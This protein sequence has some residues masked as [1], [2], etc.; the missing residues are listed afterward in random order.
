MRKIAIILLF[1]SSICSA[2]FVT[3]YHGQLI[4][5]NGKPIY[6]PSVVYFYS[7]QGAS[8]VQSSITLRM[9]TGHSCIINWGDG[10]TTNVTATTN[11]AYTSSYTLQNRSILIQITGDLGYIQHFETSSNNINLSTFSSIKLL[12]GLLELKL[13]NCSASLLNLANLNTGLTQL[14]TG[15]VQN[16]TGSITPFVN[17]TL[18][19]IEGNNCSVTGSAA[20]ATGLISYI[21]S[22]SST[23]STNITNLVNL[24]TLTV[25]GTPT[26]TGNCT[27]ATGM[28]SINVQNS[29]TFS[30]NLTGWTNLVFTQILDDNAS[31]SG[32]LSSTAITSLNIQSTLATFSVII[33]PLSNLTALALKGPSIVATGSING[34]NLV[35]Y[36]L[37]NGTNITLSGSIN[38]LSPTIYYLSIHGSGLIFSGSLTGRTSITTLVINGNNMTIGGSTTGIAAT[39]YVNISGTSLTFTTIDASSMTAATSFTFV[40]GSTLISITN[41]T[42]SAVVTNYDCNGNGLTSLNLS[43][44]TN[45]GGITYGYNNTGLITLTMPTINKQFTNIDFHGCALNQT[46]VDNLLAALDAYYS[47]HPPTANLSVAIQ[48]G[49][50]ASPTGGSSNT[51]WVHI[52]SIFTPLG[53]S[54]SLNRN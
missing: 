13:A 32:A 18:L 17:L 14:S 36:L 39:G 19:D 1:I 4:R 24:Q 45:L 35:R 38:N 44:F 12:T 40:E 26:I 46:S 16:I 22:G 27:N 3:N 43:G 5:V 10:T 37:L 54:A 51:N 11:T 34:L 42:S 28:L 33:T 25:Y 23:I 53:K 8:N 47:A 9:A 48:A 50:N 29:S 31:I 41:L 49:T 52:L 30:A 6:Q 15:S 20:N 2:Q 7:N 21:T